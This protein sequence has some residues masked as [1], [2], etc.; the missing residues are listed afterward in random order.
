VKLV[1]SMSGAVTERLGYAAFG[2]AKPATSMPKGFIGE[3]P[4]V[5]T[6]LIYLN[7]RYY[8]PASGLFS[9][10]DDWDPTLPGVGT[11]RYAYAGNDPVNKSD[12]NGHATGCGSGCQE[13][14]NRAR[15]EAERRNTIEKKAKELSKK[16]TF[17]DLQ[18]GNLNV[19]RGAAPEVAQRAIEIRLQSASGRADT[20]DGVFGLLPGGGT[21]KPALSL[22]K[23][24]E[25]SFQRVMQKN[26][27][28]AVTKLGPGK[29]ALYG[30]YVH[31]EFQIANKAAGIK[32]EISYLNGEV[33]KHGTAG[34]IRVDAVRG[35]VDA[36]KAIADLKTGMGALTAARV[37]EIRIHLPAG[38]QGIPIFE[39]RP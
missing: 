27:T 4:D 18:K 32:T 1:T 19:L 21:L 38:Y 6:G 37:S 2:E 13:S 34:S 9:S 5:E 39:V 20:A 35:A 12:P 24:G 22:F 31:T 26:A 10:P 15:Q 8:D 36:P 29:G 14:A 30:T 11:N 16:F 23:I 17:S 28:E 25:R 7:A 33:V 3:R